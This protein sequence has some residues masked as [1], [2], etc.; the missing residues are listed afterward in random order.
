[1]FHTVGVDQP[2]GENVA[3]FVTILSTTKSQ[4]DTI[5]SYDSYLKDGEQ[6]IDDW[7]KIGCWS[8]LWKIELTSEKLHPQ[9]GKN[10]NE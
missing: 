10:E 7:I 1:M 8:P 2:V 4:R 3:Q 6:S 5:N 9:Q